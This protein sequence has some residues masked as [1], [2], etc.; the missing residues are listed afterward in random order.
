[1]IKLITKHKT[2]TVGLIAM[3]FLVGGMV[4]WMAGSIDAM[5]LGAFAGSV[6]AIATVL[7]G[8]LSKDG[9]VKKSADEQ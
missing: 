4:R 9:T 1:M 7:L 3:A 6:G 5:E 8:L 2:T